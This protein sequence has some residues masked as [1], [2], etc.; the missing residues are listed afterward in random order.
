MLLLKV[1]GLPSASN[2]FSPNDLF[3][4]SMILCTIQVNENCSFTL[5]Q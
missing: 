4:G 5:K 3:T 2:L 1:E